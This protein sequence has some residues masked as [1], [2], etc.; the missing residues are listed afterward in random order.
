[1]EQLVCKNLA[2]GYEG[3]T[4]CENI[5]LTVNEGDYLCVVGENGTGKS[6][7]IKTIIG[8]LQPV[9]GEIATAEGLSRRNIGYLPQQTPVQRDFPA[10][11]FEVVI[12]GCL[13]KRGTRPFYGKAEKQTAETN[14]KR[15]GIW[16]LARK[17]YRELSG[18]QQQ[19]IL[20]AR[21][22]CA[23][24]KIILLDEPAAGL[25]PHAT[26]EMYDI[27]RRLNKED[28]M[29]VI[30]VSHDKMAIEYATHVLH[31]GE[32]PLFCGSKADYLKSEA[33]RLFICSCG[34]NHD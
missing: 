5:N 34:G 28:K 6:T 16:N 19:R 29:T 23:A 10:S 15:L 30:M 32:K 9:S 25:D 17:C 1:M 3:K 27:I 18:G 4:V 2:L 13:G 21:A 31:L 8:L 26:A 14:M 33:A 22:L 20:L 24:E 11:A 7:F 12:S